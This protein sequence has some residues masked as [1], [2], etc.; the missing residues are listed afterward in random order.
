MVGARR[1][2]R[3]VNSRTRQDLAWIQNHAQTLHSRVR[4]IQ[5]ASQIPPRACVCMP[6]GSS[7][8][9]CFVRFD[10]FNPVILHE[11]SHVFNHRLV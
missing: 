11:D 3:E 8:E 10:A 9:S 2:V 6:C 4:R 7:R 5:F 1:R